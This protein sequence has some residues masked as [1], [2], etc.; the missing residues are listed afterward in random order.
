MKILQYMK[1]ALNKINHLTKFD[2]KG[3]WRSQTNPF[4]ANVPLSYPLKTQKWVM[5]RRNI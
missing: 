4:L 1:N 3:N 5:V 2:V